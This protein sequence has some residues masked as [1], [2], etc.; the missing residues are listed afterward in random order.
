MAVDLRRLRDGAPAGRPQTIDDVANQEGVITSRA[1]IYAALRAERL[2]GRGA[3]TAM[4]KAWAPAGLDE[5]PAW[6]LRRREC[7]D[8]LAR[9]SIAR[10][11]AG[12]TPPLVV[13]FL[14]PDYEEVSAYEEFHKLLVGAW[15]KAGKPSLRDLNRRSPSESRLSLATLSNLIQG[16]TLPT[17]QTLDS[18]LAA[19]EADHLTRRK[20]MRARGVAVDAREA[21]RGREVS[22]DKIIGTRTLNSSKPHP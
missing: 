18:F 7:E 8:E 4:V 9:E 10:D 13:P 14:A 6:M 19:I 21:R 1:A 12:S 16:R 22:E 5:L 15:G 17:A 2:V 3:L 20:L 11:E